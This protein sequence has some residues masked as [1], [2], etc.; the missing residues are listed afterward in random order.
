M[1]LLPPIDTTSALKVGVR[2]VRPGPPVS[3][4]EAE[5]VVAGL[6]RALVASVEPALEAT[7]LG[8]EATGEHAVIDRAEWLRLNLEML[9]AM[10]SRIDSEQGRASLVARIQGGCN[11]AQVGGAF[12]FVAT[13][14]LGQYFPYR[15]DGL[16]ALVAPNMAVAESELRVSP[17]DFRLWVAI[18]ERTHQLQFAKAPWLADFLA[19]AL[20]SLLDSDERNSLPQPGMGLAGVF[21]GP[22]QRAAFET[23][24]AVMAL[25]EGYAD[26]MM[27]RVGPSVVPS[28]HQLRSRFAKRRA[29][30]GW[31]RLVNKLLGMDLKLAQYKQGADFANAVIS[32]VGVEGLNAVYE[33]RDLMPLPAEIVEPELWVQRVHS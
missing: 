30:R 25:L 7:R 21:L 6:N 27:D 29:K 32:K 31:A 9:D 22:E 1:V 18:H 23:V 5:A 10:L 4:P 14:V 12:S 8:V 28:L 17:A 19:D 24:S 26:V 13:R 3:L 2:I 33:S 20:A 15:P 11:G 16:L